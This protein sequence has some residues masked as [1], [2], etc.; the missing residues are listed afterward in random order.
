[1]ADL[2]AIQHEGLY[3]PLQVILLH[4]TSQITVVLNG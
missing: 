2:Q 3:C 1:M 4:T